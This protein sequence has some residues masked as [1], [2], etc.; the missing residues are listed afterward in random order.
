ME[1]NAK[2]E[3]GKGKR[4]GGK[5]EE[6][7]EVYASWRPQ[8]GRSPISCITTRTDGKE[9]KLASVTD[10]VAGSKQLGNRIITDLMAKFV[11]KQVSIKGLANEKAKIMKN[12]GILEVKKRPAK[13]QKARKTEKEAETKADEVDTGG[14]NSACLLV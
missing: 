8:A 13:K 14:S 10:V 1:S 9:R 4:K 6:D 7:M 11:K 2:E 3:L 12:M 5:D